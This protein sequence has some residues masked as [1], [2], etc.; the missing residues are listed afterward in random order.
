MKAH[1]S[2]WELDEYNNPSGDAWEWP[3]DDPRELGEWLLARLAECRRHDGGTRALDVTIEEARDI[4][5]VTGY[6]YR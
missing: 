4:Y 6:A 1:V 3:G 5:T 2:A